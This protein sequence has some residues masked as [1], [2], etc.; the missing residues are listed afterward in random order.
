MGNAVIPY[1]TFKSILIQDFEELRKVINVFLSY[2][3][4]F[5][6]FLEWNELVF[7]S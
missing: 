7:A 4:W 1:T 2:R 6:H 5:R 3:T